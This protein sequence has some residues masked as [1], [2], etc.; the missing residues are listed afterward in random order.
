MTQEGYQWS[1]LVGKDGKEAVEVI[2][3]ECGMII[4]SQLFIL[5]FYKLCSGLTDVQIIPPN[6]PIDSD[7]RNDRVRVHVDENNKVASPP[8]IG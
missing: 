6:T 5:I 1:K 7:R 3:G 8:F 2:K 4:K